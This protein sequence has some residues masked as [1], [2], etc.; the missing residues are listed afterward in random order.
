MQNHIHPPTQKEIKEQHKTLGIVLHNR[1]L[2]CI[3]GN[4]YDQSGHAP[5]TLQTFAP[6]REDYALM[7]RRSNHKKILCKNINE[8]IIR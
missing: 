3:I 4:D 2:F 5:N 1:E 6:S 8:K 7:N